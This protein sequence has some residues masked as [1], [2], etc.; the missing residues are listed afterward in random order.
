MRTLLGELEFG[1][2]AE[3][4]LAIVFVLSLADLAEEEVSLMFVLKA[5]ES[6][7]LKAKEDLTL[8]D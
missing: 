1:G 7:A 3:A 8:C 2:S 6:C 5:K 4:L